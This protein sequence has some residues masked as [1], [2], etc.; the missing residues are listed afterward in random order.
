M[1]EYN[2]LNAVHNLM[3]GFVP[4]SADYNEALEVLAD[5]GSSQAKAFCKKHR[6]TPI[7]AKPTK[8]DEIEIYY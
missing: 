4:G 3:Y 7:T 5:P 6:I 8:E 2:G 1:T